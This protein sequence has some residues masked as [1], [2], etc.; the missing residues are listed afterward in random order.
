MSVPS[1]VVWSEANSV[2]LGSKHDLNRAKWVQTQSSGLKRTHAVWSPGLRGTESGLSPRPKTVSPESRRLVWG[3]PSRS[4]VQIFNLRARS[5]QK[6][7]S[8][9]SQPSQPQILVRRPSV[10]P[11]V[12]CE[13]NPIRQEP[14]SLDQRRTQSVL[15]LNTWSERNPKCPESRSEGNPVIPKS[16]GLRNV[17]K[18]WIRSPGHRRTTSVH[19]PEVES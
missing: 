14:K 1:S 10:S 9:L 17:S 13:K 2:G 8:G 11:E 4:W 15:N 16:P 5:A 12:C 7:S 19:S 18:S 3:E 6:E